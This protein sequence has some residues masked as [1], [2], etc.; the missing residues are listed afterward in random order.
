MRALAEAKKRRVT[1]VV[2]TQREMV[3]AGVDKIMRMQNGVLLEY[4]ERDTVMARHS[5][6]LPGGSNPQAAEARQ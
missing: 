3:L 4:D 6:V 1:V 2:I 5:F